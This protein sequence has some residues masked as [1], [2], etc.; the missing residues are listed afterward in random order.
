[1][2]RKGLSLILVVIGIIILLVSLLA[3]VLGIGG[4]PGIGYKQILGAILGA[5]IS[6]IG[7]ILYRK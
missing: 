1:M 6:I 5:V 3:D 4:Y 7:F 2:G